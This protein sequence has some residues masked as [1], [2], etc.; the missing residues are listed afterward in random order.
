MNEA[1]QLT[2]T[3]VGDIPL[4]LGLVIKLGIPEIYDREIGDHGS[5]AG[6]SGGWMVAIWIVFILTEC[7]HTKYKVEEWVERH[8]VLLSSLS[9]Q[10]IRAV[11]FNDNRLSS[12]LSRLSKREHW[13]RF[14]AAVWH[15]SVSVYE[16]LQ[17]GVGGLYSAH[18]DSTTASG[19]HQVKENGVMQRGYSKDHRP[20]LAQL[21]L[22]TIAMHPSGHPIGTQVTS[23]ETA[24]EGLYLPLIAR[25]R[26]IL[27]HP[28][29][30]YV[31]D[32]KMAAL[33]IRAQIARER[34]YYLMAAPMKGETAKSLPAW[35]DGALSGEHPLATLRK[36]N[37]ELIGCGYEFTRQCTA[38]IPIGPDGALETFSFS[39]RVCVIRS[40][41][42][43][44]LQCSRSTKSRN[45][46]MSLGRL[47]SGSRRDWSGADALG[48]IA[49][50]AKSSPDAAWSKA[51]SATERRSPPWD[52]DW[53]G[54]S[55]SRTHRQRFRSKLVSGTIAPIGAE[56]A[57]IIGSR[58]NPSEL[59]RSSCETT[60][61]SRG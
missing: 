17:P 38:Q 25:V 58:T 61:K 32:S 29:V 2:H 15:S 11:D 22:M 8:A 27:G 46:S 45:C 28:G 60:I 52:A 36:E 21:K 26:G 7:D 39:E 56:S 13:E 12:L 48:P 51:L 47:K 6:L 41:D 30:L 42:L 19:Y 57:I 4:L 44:A 5:L 23:G 16:I 53:G 40:E 20:D 18:C 55:C 43:R 9:G 49:R 37:G 33:A 3:R 50:S 1:L 31:G 59:I 54:E 35:I 34:D 24:D 10:Q 14:E